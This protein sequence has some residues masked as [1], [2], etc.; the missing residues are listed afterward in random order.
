[1]KAWTLTGPAPVERRPLALGAQGRLVLGGI[2]MSDIPSFPYEIL[3]GERV[4]RS[5]TNNTREDGHR[6]LAEAARIPV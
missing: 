4:V 6:F 5:V 2:H 1:V 3:Y